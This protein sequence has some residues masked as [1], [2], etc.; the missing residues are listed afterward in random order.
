M[1]ITKFD[2]EICREN[3]FT[4]IDCYED[5]AIYEEVVDEYEEMLPEAY[6]LIE[7][8]ALLEF[9]DVDGFDLSEYGKDI[10]QALYCI[11]SVGGKLSAW[12]SQLF[13]EGNYLG[14][15]LADAMADDYLFQMDHHLQ[16]PIISMC[17]EKGCGV[18][19]RLEA[20]QDIPM[21]AQKK[22]LKVT[23]G[24]ELTQIRVLESFMYNPVKTTCQIY[25]TEA[26][27]S[28][29]RIHHNCSK[30]PNVNCKMRNIA[31]FAV[32]V[33]EGNTFRV[34]NGKKGKS[35]LEILQEQDVFLSAVCAGRGTC[36]KCKI[37]LAEGEIPP[38]NEDKNFFSEEQLQAGMRLACRAYPTE[39]CVICIEHSEGNAFA[40]LADDE[41][42]SGAV[43]DAEPDAGG[44]YGIAV[45]IGTTTIA[46]QLVNLETKVSEDVYTTINRQRAYGADVISRIEASNEGKKAALR[47]SIQ[48]DLLQGI[49][50][51]TDGGRIPVETMVIGANTTMVHLLMGY[52]CSTLGVAPFTSVNIDTIH[53]TYEELFQKVD[54]QFSITI[55][56][57]ISTYVGGDI[58]AGLYTL[59]FNQ[60]ETVSVLID[61]GTN[62]EMAIGNKD[63]ILTASTAAGPAF[64]GGNITFG[65]GS[66][67]G[68]ICSVDFKGDEV[69]VG[70][71][72]NETPAGIC[73]TGVIDAVYELMQAELV[74][75]TGLLD[76]EYFE[77]G[78]PIAKNADGETIV[79]Y[80]KDVREIQ[81]AKAAVRAG[82]ETL[83]L[84]YGVSC[85][86]V[87]T[88]YIAGGFGYKMNI[89]KAVG[90][91]LL[92]KDCLEKVKAVGNSCLKGAKEYLL[93]ADAAAS[94]ARILERTS[95]VQLSND[96]HFNEFYMDYMYFE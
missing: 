95:E 77:D 7:P 17:K 79:F 66:I 58:T 2:I 71:I 6:K 90:I 3:V 92:P 76:E 59:G 70:T 46:M 73:G 42:L 51:L 63:R 8:V 38:S 23:N 74:D 45:D 82:V 49:E 32:T 57:G 43:S 54:Q 94:V 50:S 16:E 86:D 12:S 87:D 24:E 9:G 89:E 40:V 91:G 5:S 31:D 44:R 53:T 65:T 29:Y 13:A 88:I 78:F 64:E 39:D 67:P 18:S 96:I 61:L 75:E 34:L 85:D 15:M 11:T 25:L 84:H 93:N 55:F 30:C 52:S 36:G 22:A 56:P 37:K 72:Q 69:Q 1:K 27:S 4:L 60:T 20:P 19:R 35:L 10:W 47:N 48:N 26:N 83:M 41:E 68:A 21:W 80:Q 62:G 81:L 14:G 28:M 33:H